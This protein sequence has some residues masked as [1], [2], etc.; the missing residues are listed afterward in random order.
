MTHD[1]HAQRPPQAYG[2]PAAGNQPSWPAHAPAG[3]W[4][5]PPHGQAPGSQAGAPPAPAPQSGG[6]SSP[7]PPPSTTPSGRRR[8]PGWAGTFAAAGLAAVL[9]AGGTAG[10]ILALDDDPATGSGPVATSE[11][12]AAAGDAD[13]APAPQLADGATWQEVADVVSRSV[14][15]IGVRGATG[16]GEGSGVVIDSEG[17]VVTNHHVV[18]PAAGGGQVQV[19]LSDGR[20]FA[21]EVV[22]TDPSTDLAVLVLDEAPDDLR[23]LE[24]GDSES[25]AVGQPVMAVGNPLG[26]S[27]TVTTGIVSALDRPVTTQAQGSSP[28]QQGGAVVTNAIQSDAAVNPGN[29]GGALVD[30]AGRLVGINSSIATLGATPTSSSGS[31]GLSFAIPSAQARWVT[32]ELI[33][34]GSVD[35]AFL[36]VS[37]DNGVVELADGARREAAGI[38]EVVDGTPAQAAGITAGEAIVAVDG[39]AVGSAE[40]LVAQVRQRQPGTEVTLTLVGTGG[41]QRDVTVEFGERP[42]G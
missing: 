2:R 40:A 34:T 36:G 4:A 24:W 5:P 11:D 26:L 8:G 30:S 12:G 29:S 7:P 1:D 16:A 14:V 18:A 9:A 3:P 42:A 32:Q 17:H 19:T 41:E 38:A 31:I 33:D 35:H 23:P 21:A 39:E 20:V 6:P 13:L 22:G 15:S 10:T 27:D 28:F 25:L 37:L